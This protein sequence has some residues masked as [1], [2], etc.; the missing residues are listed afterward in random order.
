[1]KKKGLLTI[2]LLI[3]IISSIKAQTVLSQDF[4]S[5]VPP[6]GWVAVKASGSGNDWTTVS[7]GS[8]HGGTGAA[9]YEFDATE[10]ANAW[11]ISPG[12]SLTA[13]VLYT[14]TY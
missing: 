8:A 7:S 10:A 3:A 1:M 4:E 2:L 14:I 11:L 9:E 5:G 13:G 12:V 6:S